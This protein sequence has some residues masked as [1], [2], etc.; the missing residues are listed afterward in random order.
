MFR[1]INLFIKGIFVGIANIIPG[2]SGG[3]IAVVLGIFDE[4]I[5]A[6]NN[7]FKNFK[8]CAAFLIPLFIG[9]GAGIILFSKLLKYCLERYSFPTSMFF[10]GLVVGSIP[11]IYK[12]ATEKKVGYKS[13]IATILAF[14]VV[15]GFSFLSGSDSKTIDDIRGTLDMIT[16]VKILLSGIIASA[17]M[18]V[19][20]ISGSFVLVLLGMY[21]L[22]LTSVDAISS[23]AAKSIKSISEIGF[24]DAMKTLFTSDEFIIL[25]VIFVGIIIGVVLISKLIEF[26]FNKAYSIT[27][28]SILG[29]I[30]GSIY[31]IFSDKLTY[32][33][34]ETS[35]ISIITIFI[36]VAVL[37]IGTIISLI[38]GRE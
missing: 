30:F 16:V 18:V 37:V 19:P 24:T 22:V 28:F 26:L 4:M 21:Q 10:V 9:A 33:S 35:S 25:A 12:K 6:I 13:Y 14:L 27:Y 3:T 34:Y 15:V 32:S 31:S 11:L 38:L 20:G 8:K 17:A 1:F 36:G 5:S 29:L 2:V 23:T 7:I